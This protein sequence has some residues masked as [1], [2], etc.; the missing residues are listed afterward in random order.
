MSRLYST[1]LA[2]EL[3]LLKKYS[4]ATAAYS[5]Q[6][7]NGIPSTN[8][9]RSRK[10]S[11]NA[12]SDFNAKEVNNGT[13]L[14]YVVPTTLQVRYN[15]GAYF[16]GI[17]DHFRDITG[18]SL[19]D[20][21]YW[22][23]NMYKMNDG[24]SS[25]VSLSSNTRSW[26]TNTG[27]ILR[28]NGGSIVTLD[29]GEDLRNVVHEM[30]L[31]RSGTEYTLSVD[32]VEKATV[33]MG[34]TT[35]L[36]GVSFLSLFSSNISFRGSIWNIRRNG[37]VVANGDGIDS[38]DNW[39]GWT[40][41]G[42]PALF[43]GQGF[44]AFTPV[45]YD[46]RFNRNDVRMYFDGSD[47]YIDLGDAPEF[48]LNDFEIKIT[49]AMRNSGSIQYLL[50]LQADVSGED[51]QG[52]LIRKNSNQSISVL[53]KTPSSGSFF[54][55]TSSSSYSL[56]Q[57][58]KIELNKVGTNV[59]L[60]INDIVQA[61]TTSAP[62]TIDYSLSSNPKTVIGAGWTGGNILL[63]FT[64]LIYDV[65][66]SDGTNVISSYEGYG[67]TNSSWEDKVG[68]NNGT[69]NGSPIAWYK[70][71]N[72]GNY[73]LPKDAIQT[74]TSNQPTL[75]SNG[76]LNTENSKEM[77]DYNGTTNYM[78][79]SN[80]NL[81]TPSAK[82]TMSIVTKNDNSTTSNSFEY[83]LS[84]YDINGDNRAIGF[85][86]DN[87]RLRLLF[88]DPA[89]GTFE[90]SQT[91]DNDIAIDEVQVL[92]VTFDSGTC[93]LYR[94]GVEVPSTNDNVPLSIFNSSADWTI[95]SALS[96]NASS[97]LWNGEIAEIYFADNLD[98]DIVAIQ[99]NQM[100]KYSIS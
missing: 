26:V 48:E 97:G 61:T 17:D 70:N 78:R 45:W 51:I 64:G 71:I 82:F 34:D 4:G 86:I 66:I 50:N 41:N 7:L 23:W 21:D 24:N 73:A 29:A 75:V 28:L 99:T 53:M 63:E 13:L 62:T 57:E 10:D 49:S 27:M 18:L 16:D 38:T 96:S 19:S 3:A 81:P 76:T 93:K 43:T 55:M 2:N 33:D 89:D 65:S 8:V 56:G 72:T 85:C 83:L 39:G 1:I 74:T 100:K 52:L 77:S 6:N 32:S 37:I 98:D 88:G 79:I 87:Q 58:L 30:K 80:S 94:N 25:F 68:D 36:T 47:D 67:I 54:E 12:E 59:D 60:I 91:S 90:G 9:I 35:T 11:N 95:G 14:N 44:N 84:K 20:G 92:G 46:Q 22:E 5:L 40:V 15:N 42:S 69:V 31:E